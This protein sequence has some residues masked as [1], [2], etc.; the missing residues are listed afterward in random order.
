MKCDTALQAAVW[1]DNEKMV[2]LLLQAN[3]DPNESKEGWGT[4]LQ[5]AAGRGSELIV[6]YLLKANADVNLHYEGHLGSVR[7]PRKR[8]EFKLSAN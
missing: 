5:I 3:A 6:N 8:I 4:V 1:T 2:Q 7:H